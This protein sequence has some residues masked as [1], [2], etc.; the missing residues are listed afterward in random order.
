MLSYKTIFKKKKKKHGEKDYIFV[1]SNF[2][3]A[4]WHIG[5]FRSRHGDCMLGCCHILS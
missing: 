3:G 2:N 4:T 5:T 1:L